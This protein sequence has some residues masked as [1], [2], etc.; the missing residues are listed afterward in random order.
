MSWKQLGTKYQLLQV[1]ALL[2]LGYK[3]FLI[4]DGNIAKMHQIH[5]MFFSNYKAQNLSFQN[6][7]YVSG[8][9]TNYSTVFE[10]NET[11]VKT[12]KE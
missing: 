1:N 7:K 9:V 2:Y 4:L 6:L 3:T 12:M 5:T 11:K 10:K 8:E